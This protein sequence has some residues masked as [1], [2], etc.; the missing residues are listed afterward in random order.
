M[1]ERNYDNTGGQSGGGG[2]WVSLDAENGCLW[3]G[4]K[5]EGKQ[6][7]S[8]IGYLEKFDIDWEDG[9]PEKKIRPHWRIVLT[10]SARDDDGEVK[11]FNIAFPMTYNSIM[12]N[13]MNVLAAT[14]IDWGHYL[15]IV[16]YKKEGRNTAIIVKTR[17]NMGN[18]EFSTTKY[19]FDKEAP[20]GGWV[21]VPPPEDTGI[22]SPDGKGNILLWWESQ[23]LWL[24]EA[25]AFY[26]RFNGTPYTGPVGPQTRK[27]YVAGRPDGST[28]DA[29][30]SARDAAPATPPQDKS[31]EKF[32]LLLDNKL[33]AMTDPAT[34]VEQ[35]TTLY[36]GA[37]GK[38]GEY[39]VTSGEVD[40]KMTAHLRKVLNDLD[41]TFTNGGFSTMPF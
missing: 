1:H 31:R 27:G 34:V 11:N 23:N 12:P 10:M 26:A 33:A 8:F 37:K 17:P 6:A 41:A 36:A 9:N 7:R 16:V 4:K 40:T 14:T 3:I 24:E 30:K 25:K 13:V 5:N 29:E 32:M 15:E 21:G 2:K 39:G 20:K 19:A 38:F 22:A 18:G 35:V 28:S